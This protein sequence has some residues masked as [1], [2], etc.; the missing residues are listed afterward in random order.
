MRGFY[1]MKLGATEL[2]TKKKRKE[3]NIF[4]PYLGWDLFLRGWSKRMAKVLIMQIGLLSLGGGEGPGARLL[5]WYLTSKFRL[6]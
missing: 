1:I 6:D 4:R 5:Y 2:V 3:K